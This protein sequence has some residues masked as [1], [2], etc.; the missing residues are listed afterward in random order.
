MTVNGQSHSRPASPA[1]ITPSPAAHST[2]QAHRGPRARRTTSL[3]SAS[4]GTIWA[5]AC[6]RPSTGRISGATTRRH[7]RTNTERNPYAPAY[8]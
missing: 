1:Q 5:I 3:A 7:A 2:C 8:A 6:A 4:A